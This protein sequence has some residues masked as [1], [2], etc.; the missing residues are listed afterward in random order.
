MSATTQARATEIEKPRQGYAF[1]R[2]REVFIASDL[3]VADT[4]VSRLIGL[5]MTPAEEFRFGRGLWITPCSG[6]HTMM[7]RYAIDVIYLNSNW[8]VVHVEENVRPWRRVSICVEAA[9][10]LELPCYS[11]WNTGTT[12]GD[13]IEIGLGSRSEAAA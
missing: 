12:I 2:T 1:N 8:E 5:L 4:H 7:M 6:I 13:Q 9:S 10:V 11:V 3:R